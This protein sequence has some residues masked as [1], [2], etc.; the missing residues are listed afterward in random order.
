MYYSESTGVA[1]SACEFSVADPGMSAISGCWA[2][3][4]WITRS[5]IAYHPVQ[6][7]LR[8]HQL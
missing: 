5:T 6:L 3:E 7:V 1:D 2:V 8:F 4:L